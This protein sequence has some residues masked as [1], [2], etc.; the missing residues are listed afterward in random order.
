MFSLFPI[1][2]ALFVMYHY[3]PQFAVSV[4]TFLATYRNGSLER[5]ITR[6][7]IF[8]NATW[9]VGKGLQEVLLA[10]PYMLS[11]VGEAVKRDSTLAIIKHEYFEVNRLHLFPSCCQQLP[12][13]ICR[14]TPTFIYIW[15]TFR[16]M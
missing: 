13:P 2:C 8:Q 11:F 12:D 10:C 16:A 9:S 4:A 3:E 7:Y 5:L 15:L 6:S 14:L 1:S